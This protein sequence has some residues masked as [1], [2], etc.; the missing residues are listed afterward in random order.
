MRTSQYRDN[1]CNN[2]NLAMAVFNFFN[3]RDINMIEQQFLNY[4]VLGMWTLTL[5]V[6]RYKW[7]KSLTEAVNNLT[8]AIKKTL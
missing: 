7:Q 2:K 6:E 4:G 5:I 8:N 3:H 1:E